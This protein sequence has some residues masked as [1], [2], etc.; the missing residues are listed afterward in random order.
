VRD[1]LKL[2]ELLL[3]PVDILVNS[4]GVLYYTLMKNVHVKEWHTMVDV[5]VKGVLNCVGTVLG[6][7]VERRRGHIVNISSDGGRKVGI[8][9]HSLSNLLI[10]RTVRCQSWISIAF[11]F[12]LASSSLKLRYLVLCISCF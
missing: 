4:A 12:H 1:G 8:Q 5:N 3:G 7:M 6:G 2:T 9:Y 11:G 10:C